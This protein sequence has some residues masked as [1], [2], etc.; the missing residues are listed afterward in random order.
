MVALTTLVSAVP[1]GISVRSSELSDG[2]V[3][4]L[5]AQSVGI[6]DGRVFDEHNS[7]M[8]LEARGKSGIAA[9]ALGFIDTILKQV[10][11]DNHVSRISR[12]VFPQLMS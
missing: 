4:D 6:L 2:E 3:F 7:T 8:S 10:A 5:E 12:I 11:R 9:S 1:T